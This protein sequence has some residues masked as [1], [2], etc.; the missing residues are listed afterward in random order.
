MV[1]VKTRRG[2]PRHANS[3]AVGSSKKPSR[4]RPTLFPESFQSYSK[5]SQREECNS[6]EFEHLSPKVSEVITYLEWMLSL[7]NVCDLVNDDKQTLAVRLCTCLSQATNL[8]YILSGGL[9]RMCRKT[10]QVGLAHSLKA[11]T[12]PGWIKSVNLIC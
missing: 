11:P 2:A 9:K 4:R 1:R 12:L 7:R 10:T 8:L 6:A 5:R 3:N